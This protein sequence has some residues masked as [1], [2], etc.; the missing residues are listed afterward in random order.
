MKSRLYHNGTRK[1]CGL[2]T[3]PFDFSVLAGAVLIINTNIST[4]FLVQGTYCLLWYRYISETMLEPRLLNK[5]S[6]RWL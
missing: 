3:D 5:F 4:C 2:R 1:T 6:A